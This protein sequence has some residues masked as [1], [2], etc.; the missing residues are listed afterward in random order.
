MKRRVIIA[1]VVASL[2][3]GAASS[4]LL[5]QNNAGAGQ[6]Q[7]GR[8]YGGPPQSEQERAARQAACLE[9]NGGV[10]PSRRAAAGNCPLVN[11]APG[12]R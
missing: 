9:R 3:L 8:G 7:R 12:Q 11:A 10:C 1:G 2:M 4:A 6:G 5:A